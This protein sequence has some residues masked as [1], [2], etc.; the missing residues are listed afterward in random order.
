MSVNQTEIIF[1]QKSTET[2]NIW[3]LLGNNINKAQYFCPIFSWFAVAYTYYSIGR[4]GGGPI[5]KYLLY[6][7]TF[8]FLANVLD[9]VKNIS[10]EKRYH[11]ESIQYISWVVT[12][13][14]G[15]NEWGFVYINFK[16][17][18]SCVKLLNNKIWSGLIVVLFIY[19]M[20]CRV[21]IT[22]YKFKEDWAKYNS[23]EANSSTYTNKSLN[24][25]AMLYIP[26]GMVEIILIIC[27]IEQYITEKKN[28]VRNELSI[29]FNSTLSR[30]LMIS[31]LYILIAISVLINNGTYIEFARKCFWRVKGIFGIIFLVDL[32]LLRIDLD[33]NDIKTEREKYNRQQIEVI[34]SSMGSGDYHQNNNIFSSN[35]SYS[36]NSPFSPTPLPPSHH[37]INN[38]RVSSF[39]YNDLNRTSNLSS[40]PLMT[41]YGQYHHHL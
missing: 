24:L 33:Q 12:V 1:T 18:K 27:V 7:V 35:R 30:T 9:I 31:I 22:K 39:S 13:L 36:A 5:W 11:F 34:R 4:K 29:L 23:E 20:F 28:M 25:H 3:V 41:D 8:G 14:F 21:I 38:R 15:L 2:E 32:L 10:Y 19:V 40:S 17:I 6:V 16:K 26:I 37:E